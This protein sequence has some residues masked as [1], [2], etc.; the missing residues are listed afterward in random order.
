[1]T[2]APIDLLVLALFTWR[3][4][5][6]IAREDAPFYLMRRFRARYALG[7][8]DESGHYCVRCVAVWTAILGYGLWLVPPLQ[9]V[10][11][12]GAVS[13]LALMLASYSGVN[14]S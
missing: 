8:R 5:F 11:V 6:L 2:L 1:M 10:V 14:H 4:A 3:I 12:I 13:G 9:A 7:M